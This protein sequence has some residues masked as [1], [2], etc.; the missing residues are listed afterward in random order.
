MF[1]SNEAT[2]E[3]VSSYV[4]ALEQE[5]KGYEAR[6]AAVKAGHLDRLDEPQLGLRVK[7]VDA[8][9]ARCKKLKS[10]KSEAAA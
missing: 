6:Q 7:D 2:K 5:R 1:D 9:I 10:S 8:E 4:A 3:R